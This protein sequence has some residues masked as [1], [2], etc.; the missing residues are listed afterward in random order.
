MSSKELDKVKNDVAAELLEMLDGSN[1]SMDE[2]T[3]RN[4]SGQSVEYQREFLQASHTLADI[5]RL[6]GSSVIERLLNQAEAKA[7][8]K[9]GSERRQVPR[10]AGLSMA[11]G[12]LVAM[13]VGFM[14]WSGNQ[15]SPNA[16][17]GKYLTRI[18]E[19]NQFVLADGSTVFMNTGTELLVEMSENVRKLTLRRGEAYFDVAKKSDAPFSVEV[20]GSAIVALGTAFGVRAMSDRTLLEVSEGEVALL[21]SNEILASHALQGIT[22]G[23]LS[24]EAG[25]Q[26][27]IRA[28]W[29]ASL[30]T[31]NS[32]MVALRSEI[33][34]MA[35]WRDGVLSFDRVPLVNVVQELNRYTPKKIMI[36]DSGAM[37][38]EVSAG[39]PVSRILQALN[40]LSQVL[41]IQVESDFDQVFIKSKED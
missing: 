40:G 23:N 33:G 17:V 32:S 11:A 37:G 22:E 36:V 31:S 29:S 15:T 26:Y 41:P 20:G 35:D 3:G 30:D 9:T 27:R 4:W 25:N 1:F 34:H 7:E 39:I 2:S 10:W 6:K 13:Y 21:R 28:G 24:I 5:D 18:G 19:Q 8:Q 38:L 14:L 12:M 16:E